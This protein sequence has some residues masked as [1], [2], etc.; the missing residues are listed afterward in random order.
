MLIA[1]LHVIG[2][3]DKEETKRYDF[4]EMLNAELFTFA[5]ERMVPPTN[6]DGFV[7]TVREWVSKQK[8]AYSIAD[9]TEPTKALRVEEKGPSGAG[10]PA[11][12]TAPKAPAS[13]W[14]G[15]STGAQNPE[16][17]LSAIR[18]HVLLL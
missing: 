3:P 17:T 18:K 9:P 4:E 14:L 7:K 2:N 5:K 12:P 11:A 15:T 8:D 16:P 13:A 6:Y 1:K 10:A